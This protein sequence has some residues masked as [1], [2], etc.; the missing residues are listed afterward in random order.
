LTM[1]LE[2]EGLYFITYKTIQGLALLFG[3]GKLAYSIW[4]DETDIRPAPGIPTG[5]PRDYV[6]TVSD[7][8]FIDTDKVTWEQVLAMRADPESL[9]RV[10][11]LR[12]AVLDNYS[13][14]SKEYVADHLARATDEH[15]G[16][17]TK[18][19][20]ATRRGELQVLLSPAQ[21]EATGLSSYL[22]SPPGT[23][24]RFGRTAGIS[25]NIANPLFSAKV[26]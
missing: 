3:K 11:S 24:F 7:L 21:F 14:K 18:W 16:A 8:L 15:N 22:E 19:G 6:L 13:G 23:T 20:F 17:I 1:A 12:I 5:G 10:R 25:Y 2:H 26:I 4:A 9:R